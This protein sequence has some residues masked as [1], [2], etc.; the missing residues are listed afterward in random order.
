[1]NEVNY[2]G[3]YGQFDAAITLADKINAK[4]G[5]DAYRHARKVE[6]YNAIS[7]YLSEAMEALTEG[8]YKKASKNSHQLSAM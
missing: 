2:T 3:A 1:M 6:L 8:E 4:E 7:G 5:T